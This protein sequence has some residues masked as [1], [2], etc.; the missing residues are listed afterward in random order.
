VNNFITLIRSQRAVVEEGLNEYKGEKLDL[1]KCDMGKNLSEIL[2][3]AREPRPPTPLMGNAMS[4]PSKSPSKSEAAMS[5][6]K[7]LAKGATQLLGNSDPSKSKTHSTSQ[8]G[9]SQL[10]HSAPHGTGSHLPPVPP[11]GDLGYSYIGK[12]PTLYIRKW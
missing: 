6:V 7:N 5:K 12:E 4:G 11:D 2:A 9:P 3:E 8:S 1:S 10:P